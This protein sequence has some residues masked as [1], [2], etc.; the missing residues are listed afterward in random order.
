MLQENIFGNE[1]RK[2]LKEG[3]EK[4]S[5]PC[6]LKYIALTAAEAN[7]VGK[8][9]WHLKMKISKVRFMRLRTKDESS[10][11]VRV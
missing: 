6:E 8:I 4:G 7:F 9:Y 1:A 5:L 11:Q 2:I 3:M 10:F